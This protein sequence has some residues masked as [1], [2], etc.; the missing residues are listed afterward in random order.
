MSKHKHD[1]PI[2]FKLIKQYPDSVWTMCDSCMELKDEM[3]WSSYCI[4]PIAA[5]MAV[6]QNIGS[7]DGYKISALYAW[8]KYKEIYSFDE[9]L[10]ELL[11]SQGDIQM[12]IPIDILY[13]LPYPCIYIQFGD[14]GLFAHFEHDV[15]NKQ[16]EFRMWYLTEDVEMPI[17]FHIEEHCTISESIDMTFEEAK[18]RMSKDMESY[19]L[20]YLYSMKELAAKLMQ[21]VLYICAENSEIDENPEQKNVTKRSKDS[22]IKPKDTIREVRKWDVGYRIGSKIRNVRKHDSDSS[23]SGDTTGRS[24]SRKSPHARRGHWHHFWIGK[25]E[26]AERRLILKWVAPMFINGDED[27]NIATIHPVG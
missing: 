13:Q 12:D 27:D 6:A 9:D 22:E 15:N 11:M 25:H 8:R 1:L 16:F 21:L 10:A 18:R 23:D 3:Q 20:D 7:S 24:G 26:T 19:V 2:P 5:G 14:K 17:I 4:L